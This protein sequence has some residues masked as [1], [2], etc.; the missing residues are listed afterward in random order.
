MIKLENSKTQNIKVSENTKSEKIYNLE[1]RLT[2]FFER[3]IKLCQKIP[4]TPITKRPIDQ[5][6][7]AAGS[8]GANFLEATEGMSRRDFVKG[9]KIARKE[10]K[11]FRIWFRGLQVAVNFKDDE[12]DALQQEAREFIYIF[13]SII[14][15]V[16]KK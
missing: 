1:E 8:M 6:V 4:V 5:S 11:E 3:V 2:K 9:I 13:T 7:G 10:A 12:F 16:E 14:K 15:K